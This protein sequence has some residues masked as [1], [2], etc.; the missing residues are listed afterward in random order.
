MAPALIC[1]HRMCREK[2]PYRVVDYPRDALLGRGWR[3]VEDEGQKQRGLAEHHELRGRE[4]TVVD[5]ELSQLNPRIEIFG[6]VVEGFPQ[7][8]FVIAAANFRHTLGDCEDHADCRSTTRP[9]ERAD[10]GLAELQ[11]HCLGVTCVIEIERELTS[12]DLLLDDGLEQAAFIG[13]IDV[14]CAFGD[15]RRAGDLAHASTVKAPIQEYL[16]GEIARAA[17]VS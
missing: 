10:I 2:C 13:E 15:A 17:G 8:Q 14:K 6:E 4:L 5:R 3:Y 11:Q 9:A 16:A 7:H 1:L 12:F